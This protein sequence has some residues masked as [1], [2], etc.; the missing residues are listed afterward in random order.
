MQNDTAVFENHDRLF[1]KRI[2]GVPGFA[3]SAEQQIRQV[4]ECA[5]V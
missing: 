2:L 1:L 5:C 3:Y 4:P